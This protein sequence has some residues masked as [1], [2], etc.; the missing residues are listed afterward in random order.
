MAGPAVSGIVTVVLTNLLARPGWTAGLK[1]PTRWQRQAGAHDN[2][3]GLRSSRRQVVEAEPLIQLVGVC[4]VYDRQ[5]YFITGQAA[6]EPAD[7]VGADRL[8]LPPM[9]IHCARMSCEPTLGWAPGISCPVPR[10]SPIRRR[11]CVCRRQAARRARG[12]RCVQQGEPCQ[13]GLDAWLGR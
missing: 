12:Q 7:Q 8:A 10:P 6:A 5:H 1:F 11:G 13:S 4:M 3:T 2:Y 9:L